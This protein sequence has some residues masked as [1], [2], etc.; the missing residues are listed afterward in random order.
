MT[1]SGPGGAVTPPA[2]S[3]RR[4]PLKRI[5]ASTAWT[6]WRSTRYPGV[7]YRDK[8]VEGRTVG[9][10]Y[11]IDF[12]DADG[13]R[14]REKIDGGL[15]E[16]RKALAD[17]TRKDDK[18]KRTNVTLAEY[19]DV[20]LDAPRR[21]G[22]LAPGSR[23]QYESLFRNHVP[24]SIKRKKL[25]DV[26]EDDVLRVLAGV[27]HLS[28]WTQSGVFKTVAGPL[29]LALRKGYVGRSVAATL[30]PEEKPQ[31]GARRQDI[32]QPADIEQ[33]LDLCPSQHLAL[34][35]LAIYSGLRQSELLGLKWKD[36]DLGQN[37]VYAGDQIDQQGQLTGKTKSDSRTVYIP[38]QVATNL[39]AHWLASRF[40]NADD[41]IFSASS[42]RPMSQEWARKVWV[43][44]R[45]RAGISSRVRF[46]DMRH[47]F[48][49][50]LISNGASPV[51][52]AEQLGDS[53]QVAM[54]T[55]ASLFGRVE[56]EDK[57]R[58]ILESSY[59]EASGNSSARVRDT[60]VR[61]RGCRPSE[62]RPKT[63]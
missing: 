39:K 57:L 35:S 30:L 24:D 2:P 31:R 36:V 3:P 49:S 41:F 58:R 7:Y 51:E 25:S 55:Y 48:A 42:G 53:V 6:G 8:T 14:R 16:A 15:A 9:R 60:G 47:T 19:F 5:D 26:H 4:N 44:L 23:I 38:A 28:P 52:L 27:R 59:P 29:K 17:I 45:D 21:H 34:I 1:S 63:K 10:V 46:H 18:P 32:L 22:T 43:R 13:V 40:K 11:S 50:I 20:W 12:R 54:S 56:S 62:R 61:S 33:V 37:T